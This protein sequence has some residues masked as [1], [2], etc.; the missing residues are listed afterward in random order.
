MHGSI[1]LVIGACH[2]IS[3]Q[4][5]ALHLLII[6]W[7]T[8]N[9][10]SRSKAHLWIIEGPGACCCSILM[11]S[12]QRTVM[13]AQHHKALYSVGMAERRALYAGARKFGSGVWTS[14]AEVSR[15]AFQLNP[16]PV[17]ATMGGRRH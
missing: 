1:F 15:V 3:L 17:A 5:V 14:I 16:N 12:M 8:C 6:Q 9:D 10:K 4:G 11:S 13:C 7:S 2:L